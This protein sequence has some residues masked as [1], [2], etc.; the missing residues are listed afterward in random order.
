MTQPDQPR[1]RPGRP[2]RTLTPATGPNTLQAALATSGISQ[3]VVCRITGSSG[4]TIHG[5]C[6]DQAPPPPPERM[7]LLHNLCA[8]G[9]PKLDVRPILAQ[10]AHMLRVVEIPALAGAHNDRTFS[11]ALH[12]QAGALLPEP[13]R[14][15]HLARAAMLLLDLLAREQTLPGRVERPGMTDPTAALAT[16]IEAWKCH[17]MN[18]GDPAPID[19]EIAG[20]YAQII[21]NQLPAP[22]KV[23]P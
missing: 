16:V 7:I 8:P 10:R 22:E 14:A 18:W 15:P 11:A 3:A 23:T 6:H 13:E 9:R 19:A 21:A 20:V 4:A 5:A 1:R 12:L 2:P 17:S